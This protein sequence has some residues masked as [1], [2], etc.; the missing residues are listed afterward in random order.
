MNGIVEEPLLS[1][2]ELGDIGDRADQP[3]HLAVRPDDRPRPQGEPQIVAVGGAHAEI[4][5]DTPAPLL[6]DAVECRAEA[7][8]VERMQD[9]KP[10]GDVGGVVLAGLKRQFEIGAEKR[11]AKF[12]DQFLLRLCVAAEAVASSDATI[13]AVM[14]V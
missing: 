7:I 5:S 2:L 3:D 10:V 9:F 12:C 6:D 1:G 14:R 11:G 4:L 13:C 8:A